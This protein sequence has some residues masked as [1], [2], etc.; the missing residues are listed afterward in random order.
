VL[1]SGATITVDVEQVGQALDALVENALRFTVEGD[2]ISITARAEGT[3][4]VIEV[5]DSGGGIPPAVLARI[6][7]PYFSTK[8]RGKGTG[9]GL[10]TVHGIVQH[11]GGDI[12]VES[13][14]GQG[15]TFRIFLPATDLAGEASRDIPVF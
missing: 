10:A 4:A 15:T 6:F 5:A 7:E 2:A 8:A 3:R 13:Q 12:V 14:L 11:A 1:K 9:L